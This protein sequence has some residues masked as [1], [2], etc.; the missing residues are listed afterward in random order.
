M[1]H[2]HSHSASLTPGGF[3]VFRILPLSLS[4]TYLS[5]LLF[6]SL[7]YYV[8][9]CS[10]IYL[11]KS[12]IFPHFIFVLSFINVYLSFHFLS[13]FAYILSFISIF[14]YVLKHLFW[15][16]FMSLLC[17]CILFPLIR[18]FNAVLHLS[19][20]SLFHSSILSFWEEYARKRSW[21]ISVYYTDTCWRD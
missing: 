19:P 11:F 3:S 10:V 9:M 5:L 15:L 17:V 6:V 21:P 7:L 13:L 12:L 1:S 4:F 16:V 8:S 14:V 18:L 2:H 20:L